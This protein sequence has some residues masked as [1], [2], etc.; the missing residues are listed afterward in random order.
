MG[1]R[2]AQLPGQAGVVDGGAGGGAG[3]TVI[4]GHQYHLGTCLGHAGGDGAHARLADQLHRDAG[5]PVGTLQIVNQL[6]QVLDGV[7][8]VVGRRR[9]EGNARGGVTAPGNPGV[10][11]AGGQVPALAGLG[12]LGHLDLNLLGA[13]QIFTGDAEAAGGH[14]L[15]GGVAGGISQPVRL[16]AA[17][18]G[19]GLAAQQVHGL[20]QT[21]VG[22]P[23]DGAVAHSARLEALD[24]GVH[25]LH[26]VQRQGSVGVLHV[27]Q[28]PQSVGTGLVV[29]QGGILLEQVVVAPAGGLLQQV[30]GLGIVHMVLAAGTGLVGAQRV[31]GGIAA[32]TQRIVGFG[33]VAV[34]HVGDLLETDA[35][36][37][38]HGVGK[39]LVNH[40]PLDAD[41]LKD[42][43]GLVGLEGG[44]AHFGGD[45][46]NAVEDGGVVVG[47]GGVVVLVQQALLDEFHNGV[48]C[49]I[50]VDG[51][52]AVA[53]QGGKVVH[54]PGLGGLQQNGDSGALLGTDQM[55]LH[56]GHRQQGGDG[57]VVFI[58]APVGE[59]DDVGA[60]PP[61]TV[62][63]QGQVVQCPVQGGVFIVED[64][65]GLHLEAG[66]FHGLDLHHVGG[67]ED[68]VVD[69]EDPAIF[70]ALLQQVAVVA[71]V[72]GGVGDDLL[73]D[74]VDG[75]VGYLSKEL[76]EVAEQGLVP[77]VQHR[78]GDIGAHGSGG[79]QTGACHGEDGVA[80]VLIGVAEGLL[81]PVQPVSGVALHPVVGNRQILQMEQVAVQPLAVGLTGGVGFLQLV[82]AD[83]TALGGVHQQ[84]TAGLE[85]GFLH[86]LLGGNIQYAHLRGQNESAVPGDIIPGGTQAVAVQHGSHHVAIG[87]EDGGRAVPGLHQGGVILVQVPLG[88]G[89][90]LV[91]HP[92]LG[93]AG[94][95]SQRQ[96]HAGHHKELQG[97]VQH[98]G[99][100]A[101]HID[102]RQ[103]FV[104]LI[105]Q[106]GG[107]HG[108]LTGQHTV[109]VAP[110]G[111]D[112][113]VVGH[114][115]VGVGPLPGGI[116]I[117]GEPGV[118]QGDG[119]LIILA[120]QVGIELTQLS[121]QEHA[122]VD[123]GTAGQGGNIGVVVG[124]L[125]HPADDVEPAVEGQA[126]I[127][128]LRAG[129]KGLLD[130]GHLVQGLLP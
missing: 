84:H 130:D 97:V 47:H 92:G 4:A 80:Y 101:G 48:L 50:G 71:H 52:G 91:L 7:D 93:N 59:D 88:A 5:L 31:Q 58:H 77:V 82:V 110:D 98:G 2:Q 95:D 35:A 42:L 117:G 23:G 99:V 9:D 21:L 121:H 43:G 102:H 22:L 28:T 83:D 115:A 61:G 105:G 127:G 124:L 24:D 120:L 63:R 65:H 79:L 37:P 8:I 70:R 119:G 122:L 106:Q 39:V 6:G 33:V 81:Q 126:R 113:A 87:E 25:A 108:L 44:D 1:L 34:H 94:H 125:K 38:G 89:D 30:N 128:V 15:D 54:V 17:L 57:H 56:G 123:D 55:L 73:P 19:V 53:Q 20:G 36:H 76:L 86:D 46:H 18:A 27:Q 69:L 64:G 66:L 40:I 107:G 51:P 74:G 60:L 45:L 49:Q 12:A 13:D 112:L 103:H 109:H 96:I 62:H 26:L 11:L 14:L 90:G 10:D 72:D 100:G 116:G 16:L 78:Q 75:R 68:R 118:D 85:A 129:H 32:Q 114:E 67:G 29:H 41:G 104:H 3:A 111:V